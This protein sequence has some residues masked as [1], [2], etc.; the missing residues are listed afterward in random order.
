MPAFDPRDF[1]LVFDKEQ[2][3]LTITLSTRGAARLASGAAEPE[4]ET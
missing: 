2:N 1:Y 3:T 4:T